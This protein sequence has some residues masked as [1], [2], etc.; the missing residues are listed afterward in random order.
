MRQG[1]GLWIAA[2][3]R[4]LVVSRAQVSDT[5]LFQCVATN[6]AGNHNK[7]FS[8]V[9]QGN[10]NK[11]TLKLK[12]PISVSFKCKW[13]YL[14]SSCKL[15]QNLALPFLNFLVPQFQL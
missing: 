7:D 1:E 4:R 10:T 5:A 11:L 15:Q 13:L 9:V 14:N 8:V 6:E 12:R 2:G 3:G